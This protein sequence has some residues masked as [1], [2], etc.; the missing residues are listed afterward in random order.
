MTL[1]YCDLV[2]IENTNRKSYTTIIIIL[3]SPTIFIIHSY[4]DISELGGG[5]H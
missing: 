1:K 4:F 2:F 5:V 3:L